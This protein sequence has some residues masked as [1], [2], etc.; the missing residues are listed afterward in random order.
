MGENAGW[1][2]AQEPSWWDAHGVVMLFIGIMALFLLSLAAQI[3]W[4]R[5]P[6]HR[7]VVL[8]V[9]WLIGAMAVTV[10]FLEELSGGVTAN[11]L[12]YA[13]IVYLQYFFV[14]I[15]PAGVLAL[16]GALARLL[17]RSRPQEDF[18]TA[19]EGDGDDLPSPAQAAA[20]SEPA[21][22][23]LPEEFVQASALPPDDLPAILLPPED[24]TPR[25]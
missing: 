19:D 23:G 6:A 16:A 7:Q 1:S 22:D 4:A 18:W 3:A 2:Y 9:L 14:V 11:Y 12:S 20:E 5:K 13:S 10:D 25:S 24:D 17:A 21:A 15:L 8:P